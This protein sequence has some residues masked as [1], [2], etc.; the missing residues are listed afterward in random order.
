LPFKQFPIQEIAFVEGGFR[1]TATTT[2]SAVG[3]AV[4][5]ITVDLRTLVSLLLA[6]VVAFLLKTPTL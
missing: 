1:V 2:R 4:K 5:R 3:L 6:I